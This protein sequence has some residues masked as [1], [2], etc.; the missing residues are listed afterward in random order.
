[1]PFGSPPVPRALSPEW[2]P[3]TTT[4]A[5]ASTSTFTNDPHHVSAINNLGVL[6]KQTGK[7]NDALAAFLYGMEVALE[8]EN[9]AMN[10]MRIYYGAGDRDKARATLERHLGKR[11]DSPRARRA[12]AELSK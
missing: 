7:D 3:P 2:P 4:A 6:Y 10:L 9:I 11:P 1:M 12:L 8:D 5:A